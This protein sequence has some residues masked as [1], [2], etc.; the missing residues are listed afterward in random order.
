MSCHLAGKV[1]KVAFCVWAPFIKERKSTQ[2][3]FVCVETHNVG[4]FLD[5]SKNFQK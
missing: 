2:L 4:K 5:G 3:F 1:I